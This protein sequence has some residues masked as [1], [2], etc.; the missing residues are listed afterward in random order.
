MGMS[1]EKIISV[2]FKNEQCNILAGKKKKLENK[3]PY[4]GPESPK[5]NIFDII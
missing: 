3:G 4:L 2:F 1:T 5:L